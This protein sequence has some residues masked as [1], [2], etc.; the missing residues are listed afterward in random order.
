MGG[1]GLQ[2]GRGLKLLFVSYKKKRKE[3]DKV[4]TMLNGSGVVG[5]AQHVFNLLKWWYKGFYPVWTRGEGS[6]NVYHNRLSNTLYCKEVT[7]LRLVYP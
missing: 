2:N 7:F 4:V 6:Q 1:G 3:V 5:E